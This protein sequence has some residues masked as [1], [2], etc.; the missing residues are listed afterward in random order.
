MITEKRIYETICFMD[1]ILKDAGF[2]TPHIA[3]AALNPHEGEGG[4]FGK[5]KIVAIEPAI[6]KARLNNINVNGP[7]PA[8]TIFLKV[9]KEKYNGV[10]SMY[11]DQGQ[12]ATKIMGFEK[13][14]LYMEGCQYLLQHVPIELLL[15]SQAK[16]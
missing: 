15:I 12:I 16:E 8:D 10:I 2:H 13:G 1:S 11:H 4:M 5:E 9:W 3:V 14:L 6:A 7:F